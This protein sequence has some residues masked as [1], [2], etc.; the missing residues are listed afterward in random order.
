[1]RN[2]PFALPN[3]KS[4][5][6]TESGDQGYLK[7]KF[8]G[9]IL[10]RNNLYYLETGSLSVLDRSNNNWFLEELF[11]YA[12]KNHDLN[13]V[14]ALKKI[15]DSIEY[16]E[17]VRQHASETIEILEENS[18]NGNSRD[19]ISSA[20]SE[21]EKAEAARKILAGVRYPQTTDILRLLREKS[22]ELKRLA[23]FLIGKFNMTDMIQ[24]VCECLYTPDIEAD[25]YSVLLS[26]GPSAASELNRFFLISSGNICLSKII[27]RIYT[28][29]C[30][31]ESNSFLVERLWANSRQ[32]KE[33]ALNA[34]LNCGFKPEKEDKERLV[35][36]IYETFNLLAR[37]T[38]GKVCLNER[39]NE[40]IYREMN[41]EYER[42]KDYLLDLL[43]LTYGNVIS[44]GG[45]KNHFEKEENISRFLPELAEIIYGSQ[46]KSQP[47]SIQDGTADKKLLRKLQRFFPGEVPQYKE[48]LED[49]INCDYN[50]ISI[51]T[52]ACT[53]RNIPQVED[54]DTGESIVALLFSPEELLRQEAARLLIR[55]GRDRYISASERIPEPVKKSLEKAISGETDVNE[56]LY[57]KVKFLASC[58]TN[59]HEDDLLCLAEKMVFTRGN[60]P[61]SGSDLHGTVIWSFKPGKNKPDVTIIQEKA[62]LERAAMN[63]TE[64]ISFRYALPLSIIEEY[65]FQYDENAYPILKYIDDNTV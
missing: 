65:S 14:P 27:L 6:A 5:I 46:V 60:Q 26:F 44:S 24:E 10:F 28:K 41:R 55:S 45:R 15:A 30:P 58:F 31:G 8:S 3:P 32:L 34:L 51:W 35:R 9:R 22:P 54:E 59:I 4:N 23:L 36:S 39:N 50:I 42:W 19:K 33:I 20:K 37:L 48:L 29:S 63:R 56:L 7:N 53:I 40:L 18:V 64:T 52:K 47:E 17:S 11:A 25:A 1:M 49:I 2:R 38:S 62:D 12:R 57:E 13:L 61:V 43:K 16:N 21:K